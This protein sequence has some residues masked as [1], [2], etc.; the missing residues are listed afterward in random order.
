MG[1]TR[2]DLS[3]VVVLDIFVTDHIL[4]THTS[5]RGFFAFAPVQAPH[6]CTR[7]CFIVLQ[8]PQQHMGSVL[9]VFVVLT[10]EM[11]FVD[12]E[13]KEIGPGIYTH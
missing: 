8:H 7:S 1:R 10:R 3:V 2:T 6:T 5:S 11:L 12:E 13:E 9:A 4:R